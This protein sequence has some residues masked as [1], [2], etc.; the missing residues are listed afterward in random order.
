MPTTPHLTSIQTRLDEARSAAARGEFSNAESLCAEFLADKPD[1]FAAMEL[2]AKYLWETGKFAETVKTLD[3]L[4]EVNPYEPGYHCLKG[5][6]LRCL[7]K[8]GPALR[9][10]RVGIVAPGARAAIS[11][12]LTWQGSLINEMRRSDRTFALAEKRDP[13][14]ALRQYGFEPSEV[15]R[16]A[17][18]L[19]QGRE[20]LPQRNARPS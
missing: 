14:K 7:G 20:R 17:R 9:S 12:A 1:H 2:H 5:M 8:F 19:Q 4:I 13:A 18:R 10:L 11:E 3:R 16:P 6:S 15:D